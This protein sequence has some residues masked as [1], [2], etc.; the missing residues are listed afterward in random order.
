MDLRWKFA[1]II[2]VEQWRWTTVSNF[3]WWWS[4]TIQRW[5]GLK[6]LCGFKEMDLFRNEHVWMWNLSSSALPRRIHIFAIFRSLLSSWKR[7]E[8]G[9]ETKDDFSFFSLH[10]AS[11]SCFIFFWSLRTCNVNASLQRTFHSCTTLSRRE[12]G[13]DEIAPTGYG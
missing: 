9:N 6:E 8:N 5:F 12:H 3:N 1:R 11:N 2:M 10:L 7:K 13:V 4:G